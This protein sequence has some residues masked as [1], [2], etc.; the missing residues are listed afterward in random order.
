MLLRFI[1]LK[2]M[3]TTELSVNAK[4][5]SDL[6]N[7]NLELLSGKCPDRIEIQDYYLGILKR[8]VILLSDLSKILNNRDREHISTPFIILRSLLDDFLHLVYLELHSDKEAE[9]TKINASTHKQS[10]KSLDNLANSSYEHMTHTKLK[11][12]KAI[13]K[14][15]DGNKKYF[16]NVQSFKFIGFMIFDEMVNSISLPSDIEMFKVRAYYLWKEFSSFVHYSNYSFDYEMADA[17]QNLLMI[18]ES[19]QYCYNSIYLAFKYFER[20]LK[21]GFKDNVELGSKYGIILK[22]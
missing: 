9:I 7:E 19:L 3:T 5:L 17:E 13:F 8:Q 10:F 16:K 21:I 1:L 18:D 11:E 6:A 15:K 14:S 20:T 22:C 12:V 4:K 2:I